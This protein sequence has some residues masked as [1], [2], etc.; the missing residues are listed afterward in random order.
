MQKNAP[1]LQAMSETPQDTSANRNRLSYVLGN[2]LKM[3]VPMTSSKTMDPKVSAANHA[4]IIQAMQDDLIK[5][6]LWAV[7]DGIRKY[8]QSVEGKWAPKTS[9]EL[10]P[11]I[12]ESLSIVNYT[13]KNCRRVLVA[14]ERGLNVD[15]MTAT[16]N[17]IEDQKVKAEMA[18][19][20]MGSLEKSCNI[21]TDSV[22][23]SLY[24]R[25]YIIFHTWRKDNA[26]EFVS[27]S[28]GKEEDAP[29]GTGDPDRGVQT[30]NPADEAPK[31]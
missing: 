12:V 27:A 26:K 16:L 5:Y 9:G 25:C 22:G 19:Q 21:W 10:I 13:L 30:S 20:I 14:H 7:E 18:L 2:F 29:T 17:E 24:D 4:A 11:H 23:K 8:R 28:K 31:V 6:P 15:E 1:A 3:Y